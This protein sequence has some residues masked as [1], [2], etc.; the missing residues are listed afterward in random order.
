[1]YKTYIMFRTKFLDKDDS[2]N[3]I[4]YDLICSIREWHKTLSEEDAKTVKIIRCDDYYH[5]SSIIVLFEHFNQDNY[6]GQTMVCVPQNSGNPCIVF[7][8][9]SHRNDLIMA[10]MAGAQIQEFTND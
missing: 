5:S 3:I 9:P 2:F 7:L 4:G 1:M 6:M 8:Y 10:L